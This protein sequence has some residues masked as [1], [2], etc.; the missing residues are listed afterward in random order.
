[1]H[2]QVF[3][4]YPDELEKESFLRATSIPAMTSVENL[5]SY[6][7]GKKTKT[8]RGPAWAHV[9]LSVF[10]LTSASETFSMPTVA[11]PLIVWVMA[12]DAETQEREGDGPWLTSRVTQGSLFVTAAGAPY[13]FRWKR[14]SEGPL[15]VAMALLDLGLFEAALQE[16]HG[17]NAA[18]ATLQDVSASEDLALVRLLQ[19]LLAEAEQV[20]ASAVFT[21][22]IAQAICV[23]LARNYVELDLGS[24]RTA[25][26]LPVF[27]LRHVTTWMSEHLVQEF[28]L[29]ILAEQVG[30][31]DYHFNRLFKRA[32]G[33]PPSQYFIQ[34]RMGE[35]RRLLRETEMT[36]VTVANEVGY[37]NPSHFS[38]IF[39]K[40]TGFSPSDYRRQR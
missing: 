12:G 6:P 4:S 20:E 14:L 19:C 39:R 10:S 11:E 7:A 9:R 13:E 32:V 3:Q 29:R 21:H 23:H 36:V 22:A 1:M 28:S 8:T 24:S 37:S 16:I 31:S 27:K 35:A 25:P 15:E 5:D 17:V 2:I 34:L 26:S 30:L 38:R 18:H 33:M 40:A